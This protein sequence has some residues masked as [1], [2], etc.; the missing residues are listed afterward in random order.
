MAP[1][2][3]YPAFREELVCAL[4]ETLINHPRAKAMSS[5]A[6]K[7]AGALADGQQE[8]SLADAVQALSIQQTPPRT[9]GNHLY[10]FFNFHV[11]AK[12]Q[13]T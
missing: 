8:E 2:A 10:H 1:D 12:L 7:P 5:C 4:L 9:P 6:A 3:Q 11:H 13:A